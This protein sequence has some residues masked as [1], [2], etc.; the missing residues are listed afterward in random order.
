MG[1]STGISQDKQVKRSGPKAVYLACPE[2]QA[3]RGKWQRSAVDVLCPCRLASHRRRQGALPGWKD[4]TLLCSQLVPVAT[5]L[6]PTAPAPCLRPASDS[7]NWIRGR[8]RSGAY[9]HFILSLP[10][11]GAADEKG[12][13]LLHSRLARRSGQSS[14]CAVAGGHRKPEQTAR[15]A[16][17]F[18][19]VCAESAP[20][21][22]GTQELRE[23]CNQRR[24][25]SGP[26]SVLS[27]RPQSPSL[28]DS[29]GKA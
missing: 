25:Q 22:T 2:H 23:Q 10:V 13:P 20:W 1:L 27:P 12:S 17:A 29:C 7:F 8:V 5:A 21:L 6:R 9:L 14:S 15:F 19:L 18:A 28:P 4:L 16:F 11:H 24:R 26:R 3:W